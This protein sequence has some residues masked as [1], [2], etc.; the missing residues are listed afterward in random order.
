M[1]SND[2]LSPRDRWARL[3]YAIVGGLLAAPPKS[4]ELRPR[5]QELAKQAYRH[6]LRDE[7]ICF[8]YSTLER[9]WYCCKNATD[10]VAALRE[11]PRSHAGRVRS[12]TPTAIEALTA[13]YR[14]HPNW[15]AQLLTDNLK[16]VLAEREPGR[17]APSYSSVRRYLKAWGM[18]KRPRAYGRGERGALERGRAGAE[19][20]R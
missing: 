18:F 9:W 13:L 1:S 19:S 7:E 5:L 6:P 3:R 10:P 16:A 12:L 8:G 11:Y 4:G 15:S 2:A 14:E 17:G 20:H